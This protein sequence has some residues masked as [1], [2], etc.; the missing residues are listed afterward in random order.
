MKS[1]GVIT[2]MNVTFSN[3]IE[4]TLFKDQPL[5]M[6][7]FLGKTIK[8]THTGRF[9]CVSCK[10][11]IKK[12][13]GQGFCYPCFQNSPQNSPC[14]LR[15]ELC[16]AHLGIGRDMEWETKHHLQPHVVYLTASDQ[17]KVGITQQVNV[18]SRWIDQGAIKAIVLA[19]TE[20][21]YLAGILEVAMKDFFTDKTNWQSMLKNHSDP[22]I[23]L[24]EAKWETAESLPQDMQDLFV[25]DDD[26]LEL[27]YPVLSYPEKVKSIKLDNFPIIE[28]VLVG[29]K[30]QYLIF[31][32]DCVI[33]IRSHSGYH[34]VVEC[35]DV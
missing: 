16:Q 22:E 18:P 11:E 10:K 23:D 5:H 31:E 19:R 17:I 24:V 28:K 12:L 9:A 1:E 14:I 2:K 27:N 8:I 32:D 26:I 21:R 33:N 20:N 13:F 6:H 4:Y 3:P 29:I 30:G 7:T 25:D 35:L 15:P 34:V